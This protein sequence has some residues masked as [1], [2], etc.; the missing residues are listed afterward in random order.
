MIRE[1]SGTGWHE[2]YR[3]FNMGHRFEL[4]VPE[5]AA[6]KIIR[7]S[8]SFGVEARIVGHWEAREK[9]LTIRSEHGEFEYN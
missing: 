9:K 4:Y 2:M 5:S 1:Q 8:E 3:V 6:G 7:I